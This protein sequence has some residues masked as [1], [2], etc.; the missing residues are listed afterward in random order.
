MVRNP[1]RDVEELLRARKRIAGV[2]AW[3]AEHRSGESRM[4]LP[5]AVGGVITGMELQIKVM[6]NAADLEF[7]ILLIYERCVW[8]LCYGQ[9]VAHVNQGIH[10]SGD[11]DL[12]M[13]NGPH[14][15]GWPD[16]NHLGGETAL[17]KLLRFGKPLPSGLDG[18]RSS[19]VWFCEQTGIDITA[20]D[21]PDLPPPDRL[22]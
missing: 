4:V 10:P 14:Y 15:H 19:F 8:R 11:I 9:D 18:F 13:I 3:T 1:K 7:V 6:H 20:A 22:L 5:L 21:V 2:G 12:G 16:N 17:P